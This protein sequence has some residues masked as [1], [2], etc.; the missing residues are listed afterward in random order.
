MDDIESVATEN[1]L[2]SMTFDSLVEGLGERYK[3]TQNETMSHYKF[4]RLRQNID[5]S[6]D[7]FVNDVKS[8]AKNYS[9][10][11][12]SDECAVP[13][14]LIRDQ[15]I[16][17]VR[18]EDFRKNAL[19]D[20]W[21]LKHLKVTEAA[22]TGAATLEEYRQSRLKRVKYGRYS[23]KNR[24]AQSENVQRNCVQC[25]RQ[26]CQE[27][28]CPALKS[29]SHKCKKSGHWVGS[30][31]CQSQKKK[32]RKGRAHEISKD[33]ESSPSKSESED[34]QISSS[35]D[36]VSATKGIPKGRVRQVRKAFR[37]CGI[38][39]KPHSKKRK[40]NDFRVDVG[41]KGQ[42]ITVT[43]DTGAK[44]YVLPKKIADKLEL[45]LE[46]FRLKVS[47]YGAK[48]FRVL[49]KY[50]G[51]ITFGDMVTTTTWYIVIKNKIEPLLSGQTAEESM[52][53][54]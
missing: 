1:E 25:G 35:D 9:F 13:D 28:Q 33:N 51:S 32:E 23:K 2:Q 39:N 43:T 54:L 5:Q 34:S 19:K 26:R 29:K 50:T 27:G 46:K 7:S 15:I 37:T 31:L 21:G 17:G 45:S 20:Q 47:P 10:K 30:V 41:I 40:A 8:Q 49:G 24:K 44:I 22:S 3:P 38:W 6:F 36:S 52:P 48:P 14:T 53:I 12:A 42:L 4:H 11:C 16:I 18:D